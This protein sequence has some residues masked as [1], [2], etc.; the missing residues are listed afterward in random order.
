M[1]ALNCQVTSTKINNINNNNNNISHCKKRTFLNNE[2]KTENTTAG[3]FHES[4]FV[5]GEKVN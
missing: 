4:F 1:K 3:K 5:E 2:K